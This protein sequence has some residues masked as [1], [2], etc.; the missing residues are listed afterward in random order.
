MPANV[1]RHRLEELASV[2]SGGGSHHD[3][4]MDYDRVVCTR[5]TA[6][7]SA[8]NN[9]PCQLSNRDLHKLMKNAVL[10]T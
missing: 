8:V 6:I 7:G 9:T 10:A 3:V 2:E 4:G 1:I 5:S